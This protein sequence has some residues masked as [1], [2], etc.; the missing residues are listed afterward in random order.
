TF[1]NHSFAGNEA[2]SEITFRL[3]YIDDA[4]NALI[5]ER[6]DCRQKDHFLI[7][8]ITNE[9]NAIEIISIK[10]LHP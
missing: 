5:M 4:Q 10:S 3:H 7:I 6:T 1:I 8:N 9:I 2:I